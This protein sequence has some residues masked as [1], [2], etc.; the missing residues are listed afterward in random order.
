MGLCIF[1]NVMRYKY[2]ADIPQKHGKW[3]M[4]R[5]RYV[6]LMLREVWWVISGKSETH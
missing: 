5:V 6:K 1:V 2:Q 4:S 3:P